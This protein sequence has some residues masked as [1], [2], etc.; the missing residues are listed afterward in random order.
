[1]LP[2]Q[3]WIPSPY[4]RMHRCQTDEPRA[5]RIPSPCV[6]PCWKSGISVTPSP[7]CTLWGR[8]FIAPVYV[9]CGKD[10]TGA[11]RRCHDAKESHRRTASDCI[12]SKSDS[13]GRNVHYLNSPFSILHSQFS[14]LNSP[15]SITNSCAPPTQ[16]SAGLRRPDCH[17][18]WLWQQLCRC[19]AS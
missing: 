5:Q 18:P 8:H 12:A 2:I 17:R 3:R 16:T 9:G 7:H 15:F 6:M 14:I 4:A 10:G 1:M 13:R 11:L 19:H